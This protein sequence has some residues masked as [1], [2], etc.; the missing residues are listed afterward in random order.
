MAIRHWAEELVPQIGGLE[1][2]TVSANFVDRL[3]RGAVNMGASRP[4][5][6]AAIHTGDA[7]LRNPV[8]RVSKLVLINFFAAIER[9]FGDPSI[10]MQLASAARPG[11]FSDLGFI[12]LYAPTVGEMVATTVDIQAFRQNVWQTQFDRG[13]DPARIVWTLPPDAEDHLDAAI[14]FSLAS[15]VHLYRNSLP[16]R[17]VPDVVRFRHPPRFN[18]ARYE[19][20]L[21]CPVSFGESETAILFDR[22]KLALP[23]PMANPVL[24]GRL[25]A[26]YAQPMKWLDEGRKYSAFSY[27]YLASELNKSPLTLERMAAS[28]GLSERTL[29]RKLVQEGYAFRDLLEKV[30]R[31][32]CDLYALEARRSLGEVAELLG[33]AELSAFTRAYRRWYGRPPSAKWQPSSVE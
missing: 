32:L 6:L 20:L 27:L 3:L 1:K 10:G 2:G 26:A 30:R 5:L 18:V 29:R 13:G 33:Y 31:D 4:R 11:S 24:Q 25:L 7:S 23:S 21:G 12:A 17:L 15:Y 16:S 8:G 14:E 19:E 22:N 9:E 28:F